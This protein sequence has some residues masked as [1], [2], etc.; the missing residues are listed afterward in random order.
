MSDA[1]A[2]LDDLEPGTELGASNWVTLDQATIDAHAEVTGDRDWIHN[3]VERA[4]REGPFGAPIAQ[5]SLILGNLV[6][7]QEQ[8]IRT[9]DDIGLAYALNYGFDRVRFVHPVRAGERIR[10][11]LRFG[12]V[13][14]RGDGSR[15]VHLD[16]EVEI[17]GR[18][19]PA[20]VAAWL[21]LLPGS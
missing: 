18:D 8:V 9:V 13:T 16:V 5:G 20:L 6:R 11:H 2:G 4:T 10:A 7:M 19:R 1:R 15:V 12:G 21:G 3:D 14:D 17:D